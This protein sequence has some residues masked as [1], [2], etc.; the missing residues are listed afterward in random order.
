MSI[1]LIAVAVAMLVSSG[2]AAWAQDKLRVGYRKD[3]APFVYE[4]NGQR[5]GFLYEICESILDRS[6]LPYEWTLVQA[7]SR[8][9]ALG[10]PQ[11][12]P[13]IDLL[14]DPV[15]V[16]LERSRTIMFSPVLFVS[17]G[18]YLAIES[19]VAYVQGVLEWET[20]G[21]ALS[22]DGTVVPFSE[23]PG[24][25][26]R[27]VSVKP[28]SELVEGQIGS[29]RIGVIKESTGPEIIANALR[30]GDPVVIKPGPWET[31]CYQEFDTHT[32]GIAYLCEGRKERGYPLSFYFGD[33]DI[34][35]TYLDRLGDCPDV[36]ASDRFYSI[37]PYALGI[38]A[39]V[40]REQYILLQSALFRVF[41]EEYEDAGTTL[42]FYL[43]RKYFRSS[44]P[45]SSLNAVFTSLIVPLR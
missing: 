40:S 31:V 18:S 11:N 19:N 34:I 25:G 15:T 43:F 22:H 28:C 8:L 26:L 30:A 5:V 10:K 33:R 32:E 23:K 37:E 2:A 12:G 44:R 38:S 16:T 35:L 27:Q 20:A 39:R 6:G 13:Q 4:E 14:C 3:A 24:E 29:I 36:K 7:G 42:P 1:H 45:S 17:G 41:S 21:Q 9:S